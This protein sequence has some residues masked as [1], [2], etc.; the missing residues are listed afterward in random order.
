[1][2]SVGE[3][4][5]RAAAALDITTI[6]EI[7]ESQH[8]DQ[9]VVN[10]KGGRYNNTALHQ[11]VMSR[12]E[13][14]EEKTRLQILHQLLE[15][16]AGINIQ[17]SNGWTALNVATDNNK[18]R[19]VSLLVDRGADVNLASYKGRTPLYVAA[20]SGYLDI[21]Q[22][23]HQHGAEINK[24][25][26]NGD[27]PLHTAARWGK[28][29]VVKYLVAHGGDVSRKNGRGKMP[30]DW[31]EEGGAVAE[32]LQ[33]VLSAGSN[34]TS[35]EE[36]EAAL[37]PADSEG[38]ADGGEDTGSGEEGRLRKAG[39]ETNGTPASP[40]LIDGGVG[41]NYET[42]NNTTQVMRKNVYR[43]L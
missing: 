1:M 25:S 12:N 7:L 23:L 34:K 38:R 9:E 11:A 26:N 20:Y 19:S 17:D 21:V 16:G 33:D 27:T 42:Q 5:C 37:A 36:Q 13:D 28:L 30:V 24:G 14:P 22:T 6:R 4:L 10:S 29:D 32:Y 43:G 41:E 31:A 2:S 39:D 15:A 18:A 3:K 35:S 8:V 40:D